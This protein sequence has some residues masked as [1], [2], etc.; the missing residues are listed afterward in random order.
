MT[1]KQKPVLVILT[2]GF[3]ASEADSTCLPMQQQFVRKCH[4]TY[5][6]VELIVL[7]F[8]YP[9]HETPYQWSGVRVMPF[10][11]RNQGGFR[12]LILRWKLS[13]ALHR[14]HKT[15][16]V[17]GLLSFW[18]GECAVIGKKFG[19]RFQLKHFC[20]ILGQDAR[21]GNKYPRRMP[22]PGN[23]L[24]ALSDFLQRDFFL[25]HG[26]KPFSVIQPGIDVVKAGSRERDIEI[27]GVGSLIPLKQY[28][29]FIK[30]V[31]EICL[32]LPEL[33]VVIAGEGPE[34]ERLQRLIED[35]GLHQTILL[36]GVLPYGQVLELMQRSRVLLHP[37]LYEGFSGA[38][39]EALA[40]GA[41]VISFCKPMNFNIHRWHIVDSKEKMVQQALHI[42]KMTEASFEPIIPFTMGN[43]VSKIMSL[44]NYPKRA[45]APATSTSGSSSME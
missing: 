16:R 20:W 22:L 3:P 28:D 9:Y 42:L 21:K 34:R 15:S 41:Q 30:I 17:I 36:A 11:G 8:Q 19:D 44:Y 32:E 4:E 25:N 31:A 26:V 38:C 23:E 1:N 37:S 5:P 33:K 13:A 6:D 45:A 18:Y 39:L 14:I 43:T 2:P 24:I 7:S 10:N 29:L 40:S 12:R 27:L 35:M